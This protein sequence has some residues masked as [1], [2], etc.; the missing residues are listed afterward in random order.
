MVVTES[1]VGQLPSHLGPVN[2]RVKTRRTRFQV[3]ELASRGPPARQA[4]GEPDPQDPTAGPEVE[5]RS[6]RPLDGATARVPDSPSENAPR[7]PRDLTDR[8][9]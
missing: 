6:A 5:I 7:D 3:Y 9:D 8:S 2:H 1:D 4:E